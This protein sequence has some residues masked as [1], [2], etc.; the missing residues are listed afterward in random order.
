M[1]D[2]VS[3]YNFEV[4]HP[5]GILLYN[6]LTDTVFPMS[7]K[8]YSAIETLLEN[9][10]V[11]QKEYPKLYPCLKKAESSFG[12]RLP[13]ATMSQRFDTLLP[14]FVSPHRR[15]FTWNVILRPLTR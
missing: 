6:A 8:E 11:F 5:N 3:Y 14:V 15:R 2:K 13:S 1:N 9:L 4:E 7:F 12:K 10:T